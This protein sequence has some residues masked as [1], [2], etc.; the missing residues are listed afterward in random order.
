M[1][2]ELG[3]VL[4]DGTGSTMTDGSIASFLW[5]QISG[6]AVRSVNATSARASFTAPAAPATLEFELIVIDNEGAADASRS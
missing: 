5:Q 1:A 4:L 6:P 3:N 2:P